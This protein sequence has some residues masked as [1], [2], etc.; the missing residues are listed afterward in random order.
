M[1]KGGGKHEKEGQRRH[2]KGK[3]REESQL[4]REQE[5]M[6]E[7]TVCIKLGRGMGQLSMVLRNHCSGNVA[8]LTQD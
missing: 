3:Q 2:W 7:A 6:V 8:N 1:S 4:E 5:K